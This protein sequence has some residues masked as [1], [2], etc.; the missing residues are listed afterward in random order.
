MPQS[1]G[2]GVCA[3][4]LECFR[5]EDICLIGA[6]EFAF[7]AAERANFQDTP[8]DRIEIWRINKRFGTC[9]FLTR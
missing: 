5:R 8:C 2:G 4:D 1:A 6:D 3:L 7:A 9:I